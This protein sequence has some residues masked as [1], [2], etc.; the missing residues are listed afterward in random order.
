LGGFYPT[1]LWQ[2]GEVIAD[3][4]ELSPSSLCRRIAVGMYLWPSM[5]R[6]RTPTGD[7]VFIDLRP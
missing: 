5:E 4:Y 2:P 7:T 3:T 6:L 1:S